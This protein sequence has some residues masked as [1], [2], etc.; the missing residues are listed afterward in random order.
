MGGGKVDL[1][2]EVF[3]CMY[4]KM[5]GLDDVFAHEDSLE[6]TYGGRNSDIDHPINYEN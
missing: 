5:D 1:E 4:V 2:M 6:Q 3:E